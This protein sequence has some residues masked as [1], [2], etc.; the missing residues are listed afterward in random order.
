MLGNSFNKTP[1][2][3]EQEKQAL[4]NQVYL[5]AWHYHWP[6]QDILQLPL[7]TRQFH[8]DRIVE[9]LEKSKEASTKR[10]SPSRRPRRSRR[11]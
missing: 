4:E 5:I 1:A 7:S 3:L 6:R 2:Q 11:G 10:S 9:Y 8:V